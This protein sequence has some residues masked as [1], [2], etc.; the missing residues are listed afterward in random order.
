MAGI[1]ALIGVVAL[2]IGGWCL[3]KK[4]DLWIHDVEK[5]RPLDN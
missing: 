2:G 3:M 4:V 5:D 1:L